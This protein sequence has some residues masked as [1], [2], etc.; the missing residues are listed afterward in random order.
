MFILVN[1]GVQHLD[2]LLASRPLRKYQSSDPSVSSTTEPA[3]AVPLMLHNVPRAVWKDPRYQSWMAAFGADT[4]VSLKR[5]G[6]HSPLQH[7]WAAEAHTGP[8]FFTS[9]ARNATQLS[10]LDNDIFRLPHVSPSP[11]EPSVMEAD[12]IMP[13]QPRGA[14]KMAPK[15]DSDPSFPATMQ[16]AMNAR[17]LLADAVEG[18]RNACYDAQAKIRS[19]HRYQRLRTQIG[20]DIEVT[21]LG[22][23]SALPSKYRNVSATHLHV[24][25]L[26][27][28]LLDCGE[29]TLGQLR[30]CFGP[31]KTSDVYHDLRMIFISHMHG[32]HHLGLQA[33]LSD[34]ISVR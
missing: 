2:S 11:S 32:D 8:A 34:R 16:A 12:R 10:F 17:G 14:L 6:D 19:D 20:D 4:E 33:L 25:S 26:G 5:R 9:A 3:R 31:D 27:G 23:G 21:T 1:A 22:T 7:L 15:L 29:G 18:Y 13:M 30:R 28:I 24:P